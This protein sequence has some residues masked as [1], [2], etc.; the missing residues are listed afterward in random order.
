[1]K[2]VIRLTES[3]L[4]ALVQRSVARVLREQQDNDLLL[5]SLA[6]SIIQSGRLDAKVGENDAEF[7]LQG[8]KFAYV[9]YEVISD[10]YM[11]SGMKS[12]SYDVP[13]DS[14]EIVDKP[15]VEIGSI[16]FC[17][18]EGECIPI[19]DNG[20]IKQAL[21]KVIEVDYGNLDI[22]NEDE[23]FFDEE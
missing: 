17:N 12:S 7:E 1:M 20:I 2:K 5:Q 16:E 3:D 21:E 13:N 11:Q 23:Y 4:H 22:P 19:H 8:D 9:V 14:D 6:Q 18:G 10:P 15:T